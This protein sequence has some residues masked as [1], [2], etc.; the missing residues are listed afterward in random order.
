MHLKARYVEI[1]ARGLDP[2][3]ELHAPPPISTISAAR[4]QSC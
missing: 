2:L 3:A 4:K 1:Q